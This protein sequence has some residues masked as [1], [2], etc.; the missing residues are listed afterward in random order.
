LPWFNLKCNTNSC[1]TG[2]NIDPVITKDYLPEYA[3]YY[4]RGDSKNTDPNELTS[5]SFP[6][7]FILAGSN[8]VS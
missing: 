3:A 1:K 6:T 7:T 2:Q 8:E 5:K 4:K